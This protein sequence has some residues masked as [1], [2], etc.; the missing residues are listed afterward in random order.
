MKKKA[1]WRWFQVHL[2]DDEIEMNK[3]LTSNKVIYTVTHDRF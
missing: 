1:V 3:K 2:P